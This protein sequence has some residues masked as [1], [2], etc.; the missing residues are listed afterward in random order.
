MMNNKL[1]LKA[2]GKIFP[3]H[4]DRQSEADRSQAYHDEL[5]FATVNETDAN[6][7]QEN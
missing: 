2:A 5:E 6:H 3:G 7:L 1:F 4:L